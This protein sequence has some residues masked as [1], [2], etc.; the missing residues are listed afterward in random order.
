VLNDQIGPAVDPFVFVAT[1]CQK[2]VV[3][4]FS[5]AQ[6]QESGVLATTVGGGFVVPSR[7][8]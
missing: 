8:S 1:I 6:Y 3:P 5:A 4:P 7:T 2:Y